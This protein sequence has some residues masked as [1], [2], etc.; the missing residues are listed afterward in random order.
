MRERG[1]FGVF[2]GIIRCQFKMALNGQ[3]QDAI[4]W[5]GGE[6]LQRRWGKG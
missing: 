1:R 2:I 6:L 5:K 4:L 3:E